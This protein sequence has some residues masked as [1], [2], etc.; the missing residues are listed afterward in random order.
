MDIWKYITAACKKNN[1]TILAKKY[2][3][4]FCSLEETSERDTKI[5]S[6][7]RVIL[8]TVNE[9]KYLLQPTT[10]VTE[11][12]YSYNIWLPLLRKLFAINDN[13][14]RLKSGKSAL[15]HWTTE[16]QE[17][18]LDQKSVVGYKI[19]IRCLFDFNGIEYDIAS[20]DSC[21]PSSDQ[22]KV[23]SDEAKLQR[24]GKANL[25]NLQFALQDDEKLHSWSV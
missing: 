2:I 11:R 10:Q 8:E 4:G 9:Q 6:L 21:L 20:F 1:N 22:K 5:Y 16:K 19:D 14:V 15:S 17:I 3:N 18:Y 25:V 23:V 12:D 13:V 7:L 24:E